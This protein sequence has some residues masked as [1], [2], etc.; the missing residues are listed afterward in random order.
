MA[1]ITNYL[2][3]KELGQGSNS[4][5]PSISPESRDNN[6]IQG[7]FNKIM[8]RNHENN[9]AMFNQKIGDRDK[10]Y[11]ALDA[12]Q[13][14]VGDM[15]EQD[16]KWYEAQK[17]SQSEAFD[18]MKDNGGINNKEAYKNYVNASTDLKWASTHVQA[19]K[20]GI[21]AYN[22]AIADEPIESKKQQI[23]EQMQKQLDKPTGAMIDPH[24]F[25]LDQDLDKLNEIGDKGSTIG[26]S[27]Q[28]AT[29]TTTTQTTKSTAGKPNTVTTTTKNTPAKKGASSSVTTTSGDKLKAGSTEGKATKGVPESDGVFYVNGIPHSRT[30]Q[31]VDFNKIKSNYA[32]NLLEKNGEGAERMRLL[33]DSLTNPDVINHPEI[34]KVYDT[35]IQ[36]AEEYNKARGFVPNENGD[37]SKEYLNAGA[38][39]VQKLRYAVSAPLDA[40][41]GKRNINMSIDELSSYL[42]LANRKEAFVSHTDTPLDKL[43][44]I[45]LKQAESKAKIGALNSLSTLRRANA[46]LANRKGLLVDKQLNIPETF[47]ELGVQV[48]GYTLGDKNYSAINTSQMSKKFLDNLGI[49]P[50]DDK[51]NY[52]IEVANFRNAKNNQ[53]YS[54]DDV[55]KAYHSWLQNPGEADNLRKELGRI[56]NVLDFA[57]IYGSKDKPFKIQVVGKMKKIYKIGKNQLGDPTAVL[58]NPN[59][60]GKIVRSDKLNSLMNQVKGV[61]T[62]SDKILSQSEGTSEGKS[63]DE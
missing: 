17:K 31:Y 27:G 60:S 28:A 37:M 36:K 12:G 33:Y 35:M 24:Q 47:N 21:D 54:A 8:Q 25:S 4:D 55:Q 57:Y 32:E 3:N 49:E 45:Q 7:T 43:A 2:G 26:G 13:V 59:E 1:E 18:K 15:N 53:P 50:I 46:N 29:Q 56:P 11:Q 6:V 39:D 34:R 16:R 14:V 20:I 48:T 19:R 10:L 38:A 22:K 62:E 9:V 23:R 51:G 40:K 41:T 42:N 61:S 52:N 58:M 63:D 5:I 30:T 44:E